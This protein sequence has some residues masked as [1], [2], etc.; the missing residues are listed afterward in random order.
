MICK[1][2]KDN[3]KVWL[4][5][6]WGQGQLVIVP[7]RVI[8]TNLFHCIFLDFYKSL[9]SP[10]D[11]FIINSQ[12]IMNRIWKSLGFVPFGGQSDPVWAQTWECCSPWDVAWWRHW[13]VGWRRVWSLVFRLIPSCGKF[14]AWRVLLE[15]QGWENTPNYPTLPLGAP[16]P[17]AVISWVW[18]VSGRRGNLT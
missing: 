6:Y 3:E 10:T 12:N 4:S 1:N 8:T 5:L 11:W 15:S 13:D 17:R 14:T 7:N 18:G 16:P 9:C 2:K